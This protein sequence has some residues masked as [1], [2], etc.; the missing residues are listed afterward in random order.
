MAIYHDRFIDLQKEL[1]Q[2]LMSEQVR[3][4]IDECILLFRQFVSVVH[5]GFFSYLYPEAFCFCLPLSL[6][7]PEQTVYSQGG[8]TTYSRVF[9]FLI[10]AYSEI[11][12]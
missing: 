3:E 7:K 8:V 12:Q 10:W 5:F 6:G 4:T 2:T 11:C 1:R 9:S